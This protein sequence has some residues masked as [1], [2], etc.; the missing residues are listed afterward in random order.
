MVAICLGG[1]ASTDSPI[2]FR[3]PQSY[4]PPKRTKVQVRKFWDSWADENL[5]AGD[6]VFRMGSTRAYG[7]IDTSRL[8]ALVADSRFSHVGIVAIENGHPVVYDIER[9]GA[10]RA[11]FSDF[12]FEYELA[13]GVK[14]LKPEH[15]KH[16]DEAVRYCR[17]VYHNKPKFD[18][19]MQLDNDALY[20]T[21]MIETAYRSNG[22]KLS[23][24]SRLMDYPRYDEFPT[25]MFIAKYI[26]PLTPE[27]LVFSP[28]NDTHGLW[29]SDRLE[30]IIDASD[31]YVGVH[32]V[33]PARM[34]PA[35][36]ETASRPSRDPQ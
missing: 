3:R 24:P 22:L 27:Q 33:E 11:T 16:V 23:E 20:C 14:R 28:G 18:D 34:K 31:P 5:A 35:A 30:T 19:A 6:I 25:W 26:S 8:A 13:F 17:S 15:Q 32:A 12:I 7:F 21:E 10:R 29:S 4:Q 36:V 9:H 2:S 1:C